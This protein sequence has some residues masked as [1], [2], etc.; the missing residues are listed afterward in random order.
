MWKYLKGDHQ[1]L[2]SKKRKA[3]DDGVSDTKAKMKNT[4]VQQG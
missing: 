2:V 4:T 1:F 3:D